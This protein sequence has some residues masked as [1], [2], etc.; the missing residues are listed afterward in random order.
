MALGTTRHYARRGRLKKV[1]SR[2]A[3]PEG[4]FVVGGTEEC[5]L[6][7]GGWWVQHIAEGNINID[8]TIKGGQ[9][10]MTERQSVASG[11]ERTEDGGRRWTRASTRLGRW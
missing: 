8:G 4:I 7:N 11:L 10:G 9:K 2:N 1:R 6:Q 5:G 3:E